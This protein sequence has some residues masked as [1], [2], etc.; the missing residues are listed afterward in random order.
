[1]TDKL[2]FRRGVASARPAIDIGEPA[3]DTDTKILN[4]GDGTGSPPQVLMN[5]AN[6]IL[7]N[8]VIQH[9]LP[10]AVGGLNTFVITITNTF[11][12]AY[13]L[14]DEFQFIA[15]NPN[16]STTVTLNVNS[17][18]ALPITTNNGVGLLIGEI[19]TGII[20]RVIYD[21]TL[22]R[23]IGSGS[24]VPGN[25]TGTNQNSF[26]IGDGLASDKKLIAGNDDTNKPYIVFS[27]SNNTWQWSNDGTTVTSF[28][29]A[30]TLG[31]TTNL[32]D[33]T[34]GNK[35]LQANT[36]ASPKP[37]IRWNQTTTVWEFS[38]DGTNF[39]ALGAGGS[40]LF[41]FANNIT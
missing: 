25:E 5:N 32:G 26:S 17:I 10:T 30:S 27:E 20:V 39:L 11:L 21:G 1:M 2:Q 13:S 36:A 8:K 34:N 12:T 6:Q 40:D 3:W 33:G 16:T 38:N 37:A 15:N 29:T 35:V 23:L 9:I 4:V 18:G 31:N 24:T 28:G 19:Q 7:A 41:N 22:F 14:G